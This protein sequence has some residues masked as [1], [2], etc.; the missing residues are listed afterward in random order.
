LPKI[1]IPPNPA[2]EAR[3]MSVPDQRMA[4]HGDAREHQERLGFVTAKR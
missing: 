3:H 4:E 2:A 1:V